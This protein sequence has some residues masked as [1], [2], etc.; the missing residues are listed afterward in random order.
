MVAKRSFSA[1]LNSV[2]IKPK[3]LRITKRHGRWEANLNRRQH[4]RVNRHK[5]ETERKQPI[6]TPAKRLKKYS[7]PIDEEDADTLEIPE[8]VSFDDI[9]PVHRNSVT[10]RGR[11]LR[12]STAK[13]AATV[14][15]APEEPEPV[16]SNC[17]S[18]TRR[19]VRIVKRPFTVEGTETL[20]IQVSPKTVS[21]GIQV[22]TPSREL[23][24]IE[25]PSCEAPFIEPPLRSYWTH[26]V[27]LPYPP[28]TTSQHQSNAQQFAQQQL[29]QQQL[30]QQQYM[31]QQQ[32]AF[33]PAPFMQPFQQPFVQTPYQQGP[34][35][36]RRQRR[37]VD[38]RQKYI[39]R[40]Q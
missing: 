8:S 13:P 7:K 12:L 11:L 19:I 38:K 24:K 31:P 26:K 18:N 3:R 34:I 17:T 27:N 22:G 14:Q 35:L 20:G 40:H 32:L 37:N 33:Y 2:V 39:Q 9:I 1:R 15:E 28:A 30:A 36:S 16:P 25:R 5:F 23:Q 29:A 21:I 6:I 10:E 4:V